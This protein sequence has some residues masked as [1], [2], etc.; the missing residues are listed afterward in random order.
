M[1]RERWKHQNEYAVF[2]EEQNILTLCDIIENY[3]FFVVENL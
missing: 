3:L 1:E 2:K